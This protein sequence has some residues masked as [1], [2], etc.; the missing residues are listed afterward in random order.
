MHWV[1]KLAIERVLGVLPRPIAM[2]LHSVAR[3]AVLGRREFAPQEANELCERRLRTLERAARAGAK[4]EGAQVLEF[5]TGWHGADIWLLYLA[6]AGRIVTIDVSNHLH[7]GLFSQIGQAWSSF[8][9]EIAYSFGLDVV[10]VRRRYERTDGAQL[11]DA[12][13]LMRCESLVVP[14]LS[15]MEVEPS[16]FDLWLSYSVLQRLSLSELGRALQLG[17]RSLTHNG[18]GHHVIHHGD[19]N[20]RHDGLLGPLKYLEYEEWWYHRLQTKVLNYQNRLRSV[21]F[22]RLFRLAG[23]SICRIW[24]ETV[25]EDQVPARGSLAAKFRTYTRSELAVVRTEITL[26]TDSD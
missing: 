15:S 24:R 6:G 1:A 19:H 5:G 25:E 17:R 14:G 7:S 12:L 11:R 18:I 3:H 4:V 8:L 22:E 10:D 13:Q 9:S 16:Q 21:E 2:A 20:A 23:F 26:I